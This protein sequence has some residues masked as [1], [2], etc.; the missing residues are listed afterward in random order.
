MRIKTVG[1]TA[2]KEFF[3]KN[4]FLLVALI[5]VLL[6]AGIVLVSCG[7]KCFDDG[8]CKM[9]GVT[10]DYCFKVTTDADEIKQLA[11]CLAAITGDKA[12]PC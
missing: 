4:K 2:L 8:E 9:D 3:M 10:P 11:D 12:C 5:G 6:V 1:N 7:S